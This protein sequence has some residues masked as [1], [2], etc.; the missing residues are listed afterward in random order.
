LRLGA[1]AVTAALVLAGTSSAAWS[2]AA[3]GNGSAKAGALVGGAPTLSKSGSVTISVVVSWAA[4]AGAT[5]YTIQRTGGVGTLGGNCTGTVVATTCTDSPIVILQSYTY[6]V[7]PVSG[8]WT[9]TAGPPA[10]IST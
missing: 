8:S 5:G 3:R 2:V 4:V 6:R 9:G 10:S 7:T 1:V